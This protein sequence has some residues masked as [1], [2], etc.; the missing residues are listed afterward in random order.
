MDQLKNDGYVPRLYII[1]GL[2][3]LALGILFGLVGALQYIVPGLFKANLSFE[4]TRPLH[5]SSVL[6]WI[7]LAAIGSVSVYVLQYKGKIWSVKLLKAQFVLFI[8]AIVSIIYCYCYG[9]FGGREY[10][11]F[12]PAIS[13]LIATA[14]LL[15]AVNFFKSIGGFRKQPVYVWMWL[16]G[17]VF[18]L[19]TF[20]ESYLWLFPY[21]RNNI[22]NDL[23]IQWK[24]YGAMVGSWN[25]LIYGS[26]IY[27]M[28][29]ISGSSKFA[30]SP[31]AFALYFTGLTNLM[32]N[33]GH[34]I[35]T[36]PT[37]SFIQYL[38]YFIS[39][40]ELVILGR[41]IFLWKKSLNEA[42]KYKHIRSYQFLLA[43]DAWV[44]FT[45]SLAI[46]I[47]IP[48]INIY[49]HGTHITVAHTMGATIGINTM[50][51][52]AITFDT[53]SNAC[54]PISDFNKTLNKGFWITNLSLLVFCVTLIMA[55]IV[56]AKWQM[57]E[58]PL[59][60]SIMMKNLKPY[61][62]TFFISGFTLT[63]GLL[64]T[65]FPVLKTQ[66]SCM[67]DFNTFRKNKQVKQVPQL[68][69]V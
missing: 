40:S 34:H 12:P 29:K 49:T 44:I 47:S 15:F 4:K 48:G 58:T 32:F 18:F 56:K 53:C 11:E 31:I 17:I 28:E 16:T 66:F 39:M 63:A 57:S 37:H 19:F 46:L 43:A 54:K 26:S 23:T 13:I 5:V 55:G 67:F 38:S 59:P 51:L 64:M 41:I 30:H 22:V 20:G 35:Y 14:W 25:M 45:L 68:A 42:K 69:E 1:A 10:W 36:V 52:L 61:F 7:I 62:I 27:L 3:L 21:F 6:F 50:L 24:S 60:F 8:T 9:I 65:I 33:W 2:V